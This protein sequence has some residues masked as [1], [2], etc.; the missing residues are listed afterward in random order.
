MKTK[1]K[2]TQLIQYTDQV[3]SIEISNLYFH[4]T[5]HSTILVNESI[6]RM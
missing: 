5:L 6:K 1:K 4:F 2:V 3:I